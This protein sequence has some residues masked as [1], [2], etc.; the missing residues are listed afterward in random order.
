MFTGIFREIAKDSDIKREKGIAE[1]F[2]NNK[3]MN[4]NK[5]LQ[6]VKNTARSA[7]L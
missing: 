1:H 6:M 4:L 5:Q 7:G 3:E 2:A